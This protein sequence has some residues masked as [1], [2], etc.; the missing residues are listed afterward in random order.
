MS[1]LTGMKILLLDKHAA[2]FDPRMAAFVLDLTRKIVEERRL[3]ALMVTDSMRDALDHGTRTSCCTKAP[4]CSTLPATSAIAWTFPIC[5]T[6]FGRQGRRTLRRGAPI[7][8]RSTGRAL[9]ALCATHA[10]KIKLW[11]SGL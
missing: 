8:D 6:C 2:A 1:T 9:G 5:R 3:T 11:I 10:C 7:C 4:S